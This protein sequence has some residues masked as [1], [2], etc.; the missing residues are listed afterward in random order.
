MAQ[1]SPPRLSNDCFALPPGVDWTPVDTAL[2]RLRDRMHVVVGTENLSPNDA[3]GYI[4]AEDV[5]AARS[6]PPAANSAV[7]GYGFAHAATG[8]G[9]QI[10]PLIDGRAAAGA[11]FERSVPSGPA[12]RILPGAL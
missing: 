9:D 4:L 2:D 7:D 1:L 12:I 6:N 3:N 5:V 11:P 10:L 8:S